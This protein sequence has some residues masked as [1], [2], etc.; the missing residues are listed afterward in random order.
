[1]RL[2]LFG[3]GASDCLI[4]RGV[5]GLRVNI[6]A[7]WTLWSGNRNDGNNCS[8]ALPVHVVGDLSR[9][10]RSSSRAAISSIMLTF[11]LFRSA[12]CPI[13]TVALLVV[14]S[15]WAWSPIR[16]RVL[17]QARHAG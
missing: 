13:I 9:L 11:G 14:R 1:L 16:I 7:D 4:V 12:A 15:A 6:F 3:R 5:I 2:F 10:G 17:L 8:R